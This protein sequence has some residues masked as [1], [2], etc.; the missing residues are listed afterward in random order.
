MEPIVVCLI[1]VI[2][3]GLWV[4]S[5]TKRK[6]IP[7]L[8]SGASL[9]C[10]FVIALTYNQIHQIIVWNYE[11]DGFYQIAKL[12]SEGI[13]NGKADETAKAFMQFVDYSELKSNENWQ[14]ARYDLRKDLLKIIEKSQQED[15]NRPADAVD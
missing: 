11:M 5:T 2:L 8:L 9:L 6:V 1:P 10:L 3:V 14:R 13:I 15:S 7:A 4:W 12:T